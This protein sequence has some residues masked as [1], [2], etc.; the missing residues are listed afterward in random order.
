MWRMMAKD[1]RL[2]QASAEIDGQRLSLG[3]FAMAIDSYIL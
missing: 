1:C 3:F 2:E